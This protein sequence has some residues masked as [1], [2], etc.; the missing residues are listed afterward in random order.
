MNPVVCVAI[1][2]AFPHFDDSAICLSILRHFEF[3]KDVRPNTFISLHR[4]NNRVYLIVDG[5]VRFKEGSFT[6]YICDRQC[7]AVRRYLFFKVREKEV[8]PWQPWETQQPAPE[9]C[10]CLTM[11]IRDRKAV[12]VCACVVKS[13][14]FTGQYDNY[15]DALQNRL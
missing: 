12:G 15:L 14:P 2:V 3:C 10:I 13:V 9:H 1:L 8:K 5:F 11:L 7:C 6:I 4:P